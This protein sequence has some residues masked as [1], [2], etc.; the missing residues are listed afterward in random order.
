MNK[1]SKNSIKRQTTDVKMQ[2]KFTVKKCVQFIKKNKLIIAVALIFIAELFLRFYQMDSKN[3][4]G[5]DQV[6]NAWAAKDI[7]VSHKFPLVGMVAKG[8]SGLYIGPAYYYFVSVFYYFTNLDPVASQFI[9]AFTS[10]LSFWTIYYVV[11]KLFSSGVAIIALILNT[12]SYLAI[13]SDRVQWPVNFIPLISLI[14]FYLLYKIITGDAKKIIL[15]AIMVGIAFNIHFTAIFFPIIIFL[16][17]PLIPWSRQTLKYILI[18]IPCFF[19]WILP[20][21]AYFILNNS[22]NSN[23]SYVSSSYHGFHLRRMAQ[24]WGDAI[25]QFNTYSVVDIISRIKIIFIPLFFFVYLYKSMNA[26]RLKFVY[27]VT[28]WFLVPWLVFTTYRGEISDYYFQSTRY[29]ALFILAYLIYRFWSLN[30]LVTKAAV[31]LLLISFCVVNVTK[32]ISY[33]EQPLSARKADIIERI[34]IKERVEWRPGVP[35]SYLYYYY[36][37]KNGKNVY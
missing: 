23:S 32:F 26:E 21:I 37:R 11:K 35:E 10:I 18:S 27:L 31:A 20:N 22:F 1:K 12:F 29:I 3:P 19:I 4:F 17:L 5:Y 34:R 8:N 24:L 6:D 15:L 33:H 9:A 36:M 30:S 14:V 16:T 2:N 7:I 28:L 25:I 13:V